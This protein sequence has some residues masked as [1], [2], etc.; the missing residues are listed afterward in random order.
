MIRTTTGGEYATQGLIQGLCSAGYFCKTSQFTAT[1]T[2]DV[3]QIVSPALVLALL[4]TKQGG[5]C[6]PGHYCP[7]GMVMNVSIRLFIY[8]YIIIRDYNYINFTYM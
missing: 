6:L 5:Q 4:Q 7:I 8:L 1:P 2:V 3:S